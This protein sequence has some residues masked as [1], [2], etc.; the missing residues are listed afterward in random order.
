[1]FA[2]KKMC[3]PRKYNIQIVV[4][5]LVHKLNV[6]TIYGI[7]SFCGIQWLSFL[8]SLILDHFCALYAWR[9]QTRRIWKP[10][11]SYQEGIIRLMADWRDTIHAFFIILTAVFSL[12]AV[13]TA[14][15]RVT[16]FSLAILLYCR[17]FLLQIPFRLFHKSGF[18]T[19]ALHLVQKLVDEGLAFEQTG[20]IISWYL[21]RNAVE[22][23]AG[24]PI[25]KS[26]I[27]SSIQW[28]I[29]RSVCSWVQIARRLFCAGHVK[30]ACSM[31]VMRSYL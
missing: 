3:H 11:L 28:L 31:D 4:P 1:M 7:H 22:I 25:F 24:L 2:L 20:I 17:A 6:R 9:T 5:S 13:C 23:L 29:N 12:L 16:R 10:L 26:R 27:S 30:T 15:L 8:I 18:T 19:D 14:V 21:F